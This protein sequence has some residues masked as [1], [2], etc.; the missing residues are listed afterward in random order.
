MRVSPYSN[1]L[2]PFFIGL[3][4]LLVPLLSF[5]QLSETKTSTH[6]RDSLQTRHL[7]VMAQVLPG[8][9]QIYNKQYLKAATY[10]AGMGTM[11][12]MGI[13]TNKTYKRYLSKYN[14]LDPIF[15]DG[16]YYKKRYTR[17]KQ[18]R[19]LYFAGAG[20]FYVAS[21]V[22][23][24]LVYNKDKH[25]PA[26][27]TILS[28]ILPGA[29]QVYNRKFWKVP[30]IYG[31]I[32]TL[33]FLVDWNNRGYIR[34]KRA[35]RQYPNDEFKGQRS[36]EE[37]K[38]FRDTYRKNRDLSFA[39]LIGIYVLNIIDANVDANLY[40]W[41]VNDDLSFHVEPTIINDNFASTVYS[42]PAFG[43]SCTFNF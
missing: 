3:V 15:F 12:Y 9:G 19:N 23:A 35:I 8:S 28:T 18:I 33:T 38:L 16:E 11:L 36:E 25:S 41:N 22:D 43:L 7:W 27:A 21:V 39:G 1:I 24:L 6:F 31:G 13:N 10:Y 32:S 5:G 29:G 26:T 37:L 34:F 40:D 42:Q 2:K 4:F 14:N 17:E 30:V 20:A